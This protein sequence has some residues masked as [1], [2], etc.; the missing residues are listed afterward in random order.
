MNYP[1]NQALI[2]NSVI[3]DNAAVCGY[4][5]ASL[6]ANTLRA[7]RDDL[8]HF[9]NWGGTLPTTS[10]QIACYLAHYAQGLTVAT[11]TRRLASLSKLHNIKQWPNPVST[12]LV[13]VTF[14]GIRNQH[15]VKQRQVAPAIKEDIMAM[16]NNL[17]GI[18]AIR[19]KALLLIGF[20]GAFRRSEL[21]SLQYSDIQF[22][23]Q[24]VLI[25]LR[26]SKTDQAREGR[27]IAIPYARGI[28][29]PV[30]ALREWLQLSG[31]TE[32]PIFRNVN[33]HGQIGA[34]IISPQSI[35]L[36]IKERAKAA[37][38]DSSQYSGHSLRA[39]LITSAA[40]AGVSSWKIRQQTGHKSDAM[41]QRYIR[42][43]NIFTD[44]A[45]GGVL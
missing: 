5:N 21:A 29:C 24:G 4:L 28:A 34:Q 38:L 22:V 31:I 3:L 45:A 17:Q 11:L 33:C 44:N 15:G 40:Q 32:G 41:L 37:G 23:L 26:R 9:Q 8:Q 6:S 2:Q 20:A 35:A 12:E 7:Y 30:I 16:V 1:V 14:R 13:R 39:G 42:D 19:D 43:A 25:H 36:V 27:K 10:E 18:K